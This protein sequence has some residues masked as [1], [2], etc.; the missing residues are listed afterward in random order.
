M[1]WKT[2]G[3]RHRMGLYL[4]QLN[5]PQRIRGGGHPCCE[6]VWR[7]GERKATSDSGKAHAHTHAHTYTNT[8]MGRMHSYLGS[9]LLESSRALQCADNS[10]ANVA[11]HSACTWKKSG[12]LREIARFFFLQARETMLAS[13]CSSYPKMLLGTSGKQPE[14]NTQLMKPLHRA[15]LLQKT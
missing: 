15:H 8:C 7:P 12:I 2:G 1:S 5:C 9:G 11:N 4:L 14:R 13:A 10:G 3:S 6:P